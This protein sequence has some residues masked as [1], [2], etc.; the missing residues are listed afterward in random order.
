MPTVGDAMV[1]LLLIG[2]ISWVSYLIEK[3]RERIESG[4]S[5]LDSGRKTREPS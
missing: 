3:R 2:G 1:I 5:T 4:N